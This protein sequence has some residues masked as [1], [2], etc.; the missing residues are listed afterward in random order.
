M[1]GSRAFRALMRR[2]V[3]YR[4]R[5]LIGTV[6]RRFVIDTRSTVAC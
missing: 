3:V 5:N 1:I 6:S 2:D 4:K